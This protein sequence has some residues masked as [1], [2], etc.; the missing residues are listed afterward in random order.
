ML[1]LIVGMNLW[2]IVLF[3][4]W[5]LKWMLLLCGSGIMFNV[6]LVNWLGL[7]FCF[8]CI[9]CILVVVVIVLW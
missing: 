4:I 9:W 7:L 8:L 3:I 2:G 5:F 6:S 1:V